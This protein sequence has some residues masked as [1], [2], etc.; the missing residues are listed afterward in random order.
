[1]MWLD[2]FV[3]CGASCGPTSNSQGI[4]EQLMDKKKM[5][6]G[7]YLLSS[8]YSLLQQVTIKLVRDESIDN[9]GGPWWFI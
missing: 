8:I 2:H 9:L 5:P 7:K 1:M 4:T 6:F 3:F